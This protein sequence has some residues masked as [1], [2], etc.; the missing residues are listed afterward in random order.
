MK[1]TV[2]PRGGPVA[3]DV[4]SLKLPPNAPATTATC[5]GEDAGEGPKLTSTALHEEASVTPALPTARVSAASCRLDDAVPGGP[6]PSASTTSADP[7]SPSVST[8]NS[9][10]ADDEL[11][12][13]RQRVGDEVA[14]APLASSIAIAC[15]FA[16]NSR[17]TPPV[18]SATTEEEGDEVVS[19]TVALFDAKDPVQDD[20]SWTT[21]PSIVRAVADFPP[22][23]TA[24]A[25][26]TRGDVAVVP[27]VTF[28][29]SESFL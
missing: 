24:V 28:T 22:T 6:E 3:V 11:V 8:E 21:V 7:A 23:V 1:V 25:P 29:V 19:V 12:A 16:P 4:A 18:R 20:A 9:A 26:T 13:V 27:P 14:N 2:A 15:P 17:T 5:G 10:V